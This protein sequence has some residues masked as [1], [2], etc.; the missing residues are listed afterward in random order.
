MADRANGDG[1]R[2]ARRP[3]VTA[4]NPVMLL[5]I[6]PYPPHLPCHDVTILRRSSHL[7]QLQLIEVA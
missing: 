5:I 2:R 7:E 4:A 6:T 1:D 3:T